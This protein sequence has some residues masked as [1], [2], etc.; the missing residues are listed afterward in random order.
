[1]THIRKNKG[2]CSHATSVT[3]SDDGFI[4]DVTVMNGC[5]GNLQGVC[6]LLKGMSAR[7]AIVRLQDIRCEDKPTSCPH[8]IALCLAEA[9]EQ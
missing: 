3:L 5:D 7:D 9:L 6:T 8:Q 2:V 1:M 4:Q